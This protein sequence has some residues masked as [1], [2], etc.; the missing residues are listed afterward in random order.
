MTEGTGMTKLHEL[1]LKM[2]E[3]EQGEPGRIQHFTKVHAFA[4][5][6]AQSESLPEDTRLTLE[7]A[8]LVHDIGIKPALAKYGSARGDLQEAEG[9]PLAQAMLAETGFAP[10]TA[11]RVA[12]LV[13]HHHTYTGVDGPD[14]RILLEADFL[15]NLYE[16]KESP[17]AIAAAYETIFKTATG[18]RLCRQMFGLQQ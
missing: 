4:R 8:A 15:V 1:T 7:A 3:Y 16:G 12:F 6:I 14:W 2:V 18:R 9:A 5:L 11:Q 17:Q 13:A 10:Q